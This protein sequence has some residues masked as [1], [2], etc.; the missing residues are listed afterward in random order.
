MPSKRWII[1]ERPRRKLRDTGSQGKTAVAQPIVHSTD[2]QL[3]P[4]SVQNE[5]RSPA[6]E[7]RL[8]AIYHCV[9][10]VVDRRFIFGDREK[11]KF[12]EMMRMYEAFT[13]IRILA[14]CIMSN[15]FHLMVEITPPPPNGLED[16]ELLNR[17]ATIY[18][19][20][21]VES[22]ALELQEAR[23][24]IENGRANASR[25]MSIHERY[26]YRMHDLSEFMKSL[27]QRFTQW[28]N[29]RNERKGNL[30][31][32]AFRSVVVAPGAASRLVAAYIDLNP[33]RAGIVEDPADYPW[34][35]YGE[36]MFRGKNSR[37]KM[38]STTSAAARAGLVR[39][40]FAHENG[41][42][43][44]KRW[45]EMHEIYRPWLEDAMALVRARI[46]K[47]ANHATLIKENSPGAALVVRI[48]HFTEGVA[49]GNRQFINSF[50]H[51]H[52]ERFGPKRSQGARP[53]RGHAAAVAKQQ[54]ICAI[55]D[56][57]KNP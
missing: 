40:F 45:N 31:E 12:V 36:A 7:R 20:A 33:V 4:N 30:W 43:D 2:S 16:E 39:A 26:T 29:R 56:L 9:N 24:A 42:T 32:D 11:D 27:V 23:A 57:Q 10:R 28:Y 34:S 18:D 51:Q 54:E 21:T 19:E 8:P 1:H 49:I 22:I 46:S 53:I 48:R 15:H 5:H 47:A 37:P 25:L 44:A 38:A 6:S 52:R 14:H 50:F 41:C 55:R 35:S 13:G 3:P 17:L